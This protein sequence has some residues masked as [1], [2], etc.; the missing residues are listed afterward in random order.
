[1]DDHL[2]PGAGR[3]CASR[4]DP[5]DARRQG[6]GRPDRAEALG[7][8]P[9]PRAIRCVARWKLPALSFCPPGV[10]KGLCWFEHHG[11]T[12]GEHGT[13]NVA[14]EIVSHR[15]KSTQQ[16]NT[17]VFSDEP[18]QSASMTDYDRQHLALYVR[19]LDAAEEGAEWTE[20]VRVLFGLDP[21][22]EGERAR[23][24]YDSH[25]A[26]ALWMTHHGYADLLRSALH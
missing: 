1:M 20:V 17:I 14:T 23:R 21:K 7:V 13:K 8:R 16:R 12:D 3:A 5:G 19:L 10:A 26:R 11:R 18:P 2:S 24:V 22:R 4:L 25:L 9:D 15:G 6:P